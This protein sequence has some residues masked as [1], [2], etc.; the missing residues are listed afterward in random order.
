MEFE[1]PNRNNW[2]KKH[3]LKGDLQEDFV[4]V[5]RSPMVQGRMPLLITHK[6]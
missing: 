1:I 6:F 4:L 5:L 3:N 2:K